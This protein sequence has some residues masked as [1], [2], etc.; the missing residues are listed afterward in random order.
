MNDAQQLLGLWYQNNINH[1]NQYIMRIRLP[2]RET[3]NI[4]LPIL[5]GLGHHNTTSPFW[6]GLVCF[7]RLYS[8]L[9]IFTELNKLFE[10]RLGS[11]Y[12]EFQSSRVESQVTRL[13]RQFRILIQALSPLTT[14]SRTCL[15]QQSRSTWAMA[16]RSCS[17]LTVGLQA[18]P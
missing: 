8:L 1:N 2:S 14:R 10:S 7:A 4:Y 9:L 6:D 12:T 16:S 13:A 18:V 17:G 5:V 3:T 15:L 11:L